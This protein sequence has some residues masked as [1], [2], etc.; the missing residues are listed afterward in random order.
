MCFAF[1]I[2]SLLNNYLVLGLNIPF[3]LNVN[4]SLMRQHPYY[5]S[6][7]YYF[8][9][10]YQTSAKVWHFIICV[11]NFSPCLVLAVQI[12][13]IGALA[14]RLHLSHMASEKYKIHNHLSTI[15]VSDFVCAANLNLRNLKL[16]PL[17]SVTWSLTLKNWPFLFYLLI[18][19]SVSLSPLKSQTS[20]DMS[21]LSNE[22]LQNDVNFDY[23]PYFVTERKTYLELSLS[24][25]FIIN[26]FLTYRYSMSSIIS[27]N[28]ME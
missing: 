13:H 2:L 25:F 10:L 22:Q 27:N 19:C 7:S 12:S 6:K 20:F 1:L 4:Q 17:F 14:N 3:N 24:D 18:T 11:L 26:L 9:F 8:N 5:F 21:A 28:R 16:R 23:N 15:P